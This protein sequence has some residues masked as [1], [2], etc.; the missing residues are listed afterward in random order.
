[1]HRIAIGLGALLLSGSFLAVAPQLLSQSPSEGDLE[2]SV[3]NLFGN[4]DQDQS[5]PQAFRS[6][7]ESDMWGADAT[8]LPLNP[9]VAVGRL[10]LIQPD[11]IPNRRDI[12]V[13][14]SLPEE[15]PP[16]AG[17]ISSFRQ[18]PLDHLN[19][20]AVRDA[21]PNAYIAQATT[22]ESIRPL[23][24][25]WVAYDVTMNGFGIREATAEEID[26]HVAHVRPIRPQ[27]PS[28]D[29]S[30]KR[31][32]RLTEC[33][34]GD[35]PSIGVKAANIAAMHDFGFAAEVVPNGFAIPFSCYDEF[36]KHNDLY[37]Y[38][39][40]I[41]NNPA[42]RRDRD[43]QISEL[44]KFRTLI[45]K[46]KMPDRMM[47]SLA[48]LQR[49][50]PVG[51]SIRCRSSTNNENI[52]GFSGAGLYD[53]FTHHPDEGHFSKS[54]KQVY[55]S[56]WNFRAFDERE[57]YG[58]DHFASAM[59]VLV[60]PNFQSERAGGIAVTSDIL[61]HTD[62]YHYVITELGEDPSQEANDAAPEELLL[63]C[64]GIGKDHQIQYPG[65][66]IR[67]KT[68]LPEASREELRQYLGTI[69]HKFMQLYGISPE[70]SDFAM[71][72]EFKITKDGELAIK[73]AR[74]WVAA[75]I[76]PA[77]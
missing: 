67:Q 51:T 60:H 11:E 22:D 65:Q 59:G 10:R 70:T 62:D 54:V 64:R 28:R 5:R 24:G 55:A 38:A 77:R 9:G 17:V 34:F 6:Y 29:L 19:L 76:N 73:Q 31:I 26:A 18:R 25:S 44:K 32:R 58:V 35:A 21:V 72:I 3:V 50:F 16:V 37:D 49:S 71:E 69:H 36:M 33:R 75:T 57:L 42:F 8:F 48:E 68:L 7:H 20:R 1:M 12:A 53:S 40:H 30:P 27:V 66:A 45:K 56:L 4:R 13:Y 61:H 39:K 2:T 41:L 74:P 47:E 23:I 46:G 14:D 52:P 43:V 63:S 15:V